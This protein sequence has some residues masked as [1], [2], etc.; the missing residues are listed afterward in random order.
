M[1]LSNKILYM[2]QR[3]GLVSSFM[4]A[5]VL[6]SSGRF[7]SETLLPLNAV[8]QARGAL[9]AW[10][11]PSR[12][13]FNFFNSGCVAP[14]RLKSLIGST[15]LNFLE[16]P[17]GPSLSKA[18]VADWLQ[19]RPA[20]PVKLVCAHTRGRSTSPVYAPDINAW[21]YLFCNFTTLVIGPGQEFP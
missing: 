21:C 9:V 19:H 18:L 3:F 11:N 20:I 8:R 17:K 1:L 16:T 2:D 4:F 6:I 14:C 5:Y 7:L 15:K 13:F 12:E 10:K